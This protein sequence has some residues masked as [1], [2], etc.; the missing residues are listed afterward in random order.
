MARRRSSAAATALC[1]L[2]VAGTAIAPARAAGDGDALE[3]RL[4]PASTIGDYFTELERLGLIDRSTG[5]P[6]ALAAELAR[7][8]RALEAGDP[9]GA[10]ILLYG[11]VE[12]PRFTDFA[13]F[14]EYQN[15]EYDLVVALAGSASYDA[16]LGVALRIV[17]RGPGALY[18]SAAHRRAVDIAL[19]TRDYAGVLA[20]LDGVTLDEPLP[21]EATGE[22]AYLRARA[23]YDKGDLGGAEAELTK[24][25]RKSRL[26]S[27]AL[28]L[29][30]VIKARRGEFADATDAFCEI[31]ETA[32]D[33]RYSFYVDARYFSIKDLARLGLGR[34]AHEE[35]RYD[36]AYYHYFQIPDDSDRL[37]EALFEAAWSMY[38]K[39]ELDT[40]RDLVEEFLKEFPDSPLAPEAML[41]GAYIELADCKFEEAEKKFDALVADLQP[42]VDEVA[43]IR[44]SPQ[45][46][47]ALFEKALD[48][49]RERKHD[50]E[51]AA[52]RAGAR[53]PNQRVLVMLRLDPRFLRLH[54]AAY[55]LRKTAEDA[56]SVLAAWRQLA[57]R[58]ASQAGKV[59]AVTL[60]ATPEE[61]DAR[62]AAELYEDVKRLRAEIRR[63]KA[64]IELAVREKRIKPA[65]AA[66][67]LGELDAADAKLADLEAR[68]EKASLAAD[69][70]L[71]AKADPRLRQMIEADLER[72]RA[73]VGLAL[74]LAKNID[75]QADALAARS[76]DGLHTD[77]RRVLDKA[78]LGKIDAI[79][80][81]KRKLEIEVEDLAQ[82]RF[83]PE[84]FD[85][86]YEQGIVGDDEIFWPPDAEYWKDEYS[87]WR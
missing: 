23:L 46:R 31:V 28:Y 16:A 80:G 86:L 34:L 27:S 26:Y 48:L 50:P 87:G 83:P 56:P 57:A 54:D 12:S 41:L 38:Q 1:A 65:D 13:D 8:E 18:F 55:G 15:A 5:T 40:A 69:Q 76:L 20:A 6:E 73:L 10:A 66:E 35:D 36:D 45:K 60:D 70:A 81:S 62:K 51:A 25:S 67:R 49:E 77:L 3:K 64:E 78:K 47:K 21:P 68:A 19:E 4:P 2:L 71:L 32:D 11:I 79:I 29:R 52:K 44:K 53:T 72:A 74:D 14:P 85:R 33:D 63:E 7:A 9:V 22:R 39:R 43:A 75:A 59:A 84:L 30:G 24:I 61:E 17:A 37:P 82:G 42:V 58:L